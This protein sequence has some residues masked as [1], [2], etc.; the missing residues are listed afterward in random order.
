MTKDPKILKFLE[1]RGNTV[2]NLEAIR[3]NLVR[4]V[5]DGMVDLEDTYYNQLALLID[6]ASISET[7]D[8]LIEVI[9]RAKILEVDIAV[10]LADHGQ[11]TISLPWA[12]TNPNK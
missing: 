4:C 3:A 12:N 11:T 10:W 5:D 8:E 6:E 2:E 9:S 1:A 7:W